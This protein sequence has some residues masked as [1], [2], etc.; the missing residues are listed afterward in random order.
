[1]ASL[2][3]ALLR[4]ESGGR[5]I[6]NVHQGTSSGQAQG[7][8]QITTGTWNDFGGQK[9]APTPLQATYQQQAEIA[10]AIP[11]KRWDESTVALMRGTGKPIDP[12]RTL[13]ENLAANGEDFGTGPTQVASASGASTKANDADIGGG[14]G[15]PQ[16]DAAPTLI[17]PAERHYSQLANDLATSVGNRV[18][19]GGYDTAPL[20]SEGADY[21]PVPDFASANPETPPPVPTPTPGG[22]AADFT[23][24]LADLFKVAEVGQAAAIDPMTGLPKL[25]R[26]QR[27]YG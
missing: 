5:N 27:I 3:G 9:Y 4:N 1:M 10:S 7:Y 8:F 25:P 26:P 13:G 17:P 12:N 22:P 24:A 19:R 15:S 14:G 23:P 16:A 20:A 21:V 2:L 18:S 11:L 6:P